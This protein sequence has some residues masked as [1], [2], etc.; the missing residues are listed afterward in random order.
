MYKNMHGL[1]GLRSNDLLVSLVGFV[2]H[3]RGE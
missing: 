2:P 3:T 1:G